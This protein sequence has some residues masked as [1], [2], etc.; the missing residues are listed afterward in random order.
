MID[1]N[2]NTTFIRSHWGK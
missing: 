2:S 1:S